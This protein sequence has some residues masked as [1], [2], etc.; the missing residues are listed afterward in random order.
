[1][2]KVAF[3]HC[4]LLCIGNM[5]TSA[6]G[7][8]DLGINDNTATVAVPT[9]TTNATGVVSTS[10]SY[11]EF[12]FDVSAE[13]LGQEVEVIYKESGNKSGLDEKDTV[14][15]VISTGTSDVYETTMDAITLAICK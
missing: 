8:A 7:K 9:T 11:R 1:M 5:D 15:D 2:H 14:Y 12:V 3:P 4:Y 10:N 6:N 13:L